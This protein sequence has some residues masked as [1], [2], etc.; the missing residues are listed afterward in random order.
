MRN[1]GIKK[2]E[3]KMLVLEETVMRGQR[4]MAHRKRGEGQIIP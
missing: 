4:G 3:I 1:N 2:S